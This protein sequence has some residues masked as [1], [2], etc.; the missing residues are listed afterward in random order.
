MKNAK[1]KTIIVIVMAAV[2]ALPAMAQFG[3][4][5][6]YSAAPSMYFQSTSTMSGSGSSYSSNPSLNEDGTAAY[7]GASY[8]PAKTSVSPRKVRPTNQE[9]QPLGDVFWPLML[10]A[11]MYLIVRVFLNKR[12]LSR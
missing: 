10:L 11:G 2:F 1:M 12:A 9:N 7:N 3:T 8:S 6:Q 5:N 4:N